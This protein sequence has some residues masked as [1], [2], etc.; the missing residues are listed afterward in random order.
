MCEKVTLKDVDAQELIAELTRREHNYARLG[1]FHGEEKYEVQAEAYQTAARVL[2]EAG[3][4]GTIGNVPWLP[5]RDDP[6]LAPA[7]EP[8]LCMFDEPPYNACPGEDDCPEC[9]AVAV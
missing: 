2:T 9:L 1:R 4:R 8:S 7:P 5:D 6:P 3:L